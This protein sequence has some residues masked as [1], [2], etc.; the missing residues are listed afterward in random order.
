[1]AA[2]ALSG[3]LLWASAPPIGAGWLAWLALVPVAVVVLRAPA[4]GPSRIA[5]PL[6]YAVYL[7]LLLVPALPFGLTDGQWGDPAIPVLV[8]GSPVLVVA[9]VA[10][11]LVATALWT[12]RFGQPWGARRLAPPWAAVAAVAMPALA[13]TALDF[14][15]SN[16]DPGGLWGTL[17]LS[18]AG[19][20]AGTLAA[21]A[22][23]WAVTFAVVAVNFGI[24]L[25]LVRRSL[26]PALVP[27]SVTLGAVVLAALTGGPD[28]PQ[29]RVAVA[30]IQPGY[31][32]A[33]EDRWVLRRFDPGTWGLSALDLARD[34]G[35]LTR[36]AAGAGAQVVVWPEASMYVD[37][38]DHPRVRAE[39]RSLAGET[40]AT[41][42]VPFFLP[43]PAKGATLAVVPSGDSARIAGS[44]PKQRPMWWLGEDSDASGRPVPLPAGRLRIGT[45]LGVD[46]QDPR[47][48]AELAG[49][50]AE[51]LVSGTHDWRQSAVQHSA[52]EQVAA[53]AAGLSLVRA[54]WR[55]G[56]AV[57]DGEGRV[58]ADA[59]EELSRTTV[60]AT[61]RAGAASTP[62]SSLG[63]LLGWAAVAFVGLAALGGCRTFMVEMATNVR[64]PPAR[65][66]RAAHAAS[67]T[68]VG[69]RD[70]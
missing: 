39:L 15:R 12:V 29:R 26:L 10:I 44:R 63:D 48:A 56:S 64:R 21:L 55:Y 28:A 68:A 32:T 62:Y 54:D 22:G 13:W 31:D 36:E 4:T 23:P 33:E 35:E 42:V 70:S 17:F 38:R 50:G 8:G 37:P 58:L 66:S 14:A 60:I 30:A 40:G 6:A 5:V 9:L 67:S 47:L 45:M 61:V 18:Q 1:V 25:A 43:E 7:E 16:L 59:G 11:P 19:E 20:P 24:G 2:A 3:L 46:S 53:E 49:R 52:Y 34:L 65:S 27:G 69:E 51:L 41:L 57:Y